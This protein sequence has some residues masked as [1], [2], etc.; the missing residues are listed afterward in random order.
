MIP[1]SKPDCSFLADELLGVEDCDPRDSPLRPPTHHCRRKDTLFA[2]RLALSLN[3]LAHEGCRN[4]NMKSQYAWN[5]RQHR[6]HMHFTERT[7]LV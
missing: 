4:E 1:G 7:T 5:Q 6:M 2:P 3:N